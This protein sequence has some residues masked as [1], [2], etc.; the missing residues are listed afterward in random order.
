MSRLYENK[1]IFTLENL[2]VIR[3]CAHI[4]TYAKSASGGAVVLACFLFVFYTLY[5]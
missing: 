3:S 2:R 1:T 4:R 5:A